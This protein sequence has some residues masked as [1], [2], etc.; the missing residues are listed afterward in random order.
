MRFMFFACI[1]SKRNIRLF[2][3][4]NAAGT[5]GRSLYYY[6][7]NRLLCR[8]HETGTNLFC[9]EEYFIFDT[10]II[11]VYLNYLSGIRLKTKTYFDS[12]F[13]SC[14]GDSSIVVTGPSLT[15]ATYKIKYIYPI[16]Y[17]L[18]IFFNRFRNLK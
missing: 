5:K 9:L 3:K 10:R 18:Y 11:D 6:H 4:E 17:D 13:A 1:Y 14:T 15:I 16:I 7:S 12:V 8:Q 2:N